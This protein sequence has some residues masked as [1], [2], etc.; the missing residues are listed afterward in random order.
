VG[1]ATEV[2]LS[3]RALQEGFRRHV[4]MAPMAYLRTVRLRRA[5]TALKD[6][7][8]AETTV[9]AVAVS[10]GLLHQGRFAAQYRA[11]FGEMPSETLHR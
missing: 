7:N 9:Q 8:P 11:V 2:H 4:G 3:V 6:A 5:H 10:L 1:L